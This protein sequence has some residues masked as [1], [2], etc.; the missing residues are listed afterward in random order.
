MFSVPDPDFLDTAALFSTYIVL[1]VGGRTSL[2][3]D[4]ADQ[5]YQGS[6]GAWRSYVSGEDTEGALFAPTSVNGQNI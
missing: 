4:Q 1:E 6:P 2:F 5:Y 3:P